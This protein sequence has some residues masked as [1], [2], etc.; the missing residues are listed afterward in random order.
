[1]FRYPCAHDKLLATVRHDSTSRGTLSSKSY[2]VDV[3]EKKVSR[4]PDRD[5][6]KI[7][8]QKK[9]SCD[10][11]SNHPVC[12]DGAMQFSGQKLGWNTLV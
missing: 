10:R 5:A 2:D 12:D 8:V 6:L 9:I 7:S 3:I 4:R 1:V 11:Y